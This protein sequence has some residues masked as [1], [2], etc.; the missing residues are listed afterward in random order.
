MISLGGGLPSS[1]Y[2]P[3]ENI[4]VKAP[5]FSSSLEGGMRKTEETLSIGKNDVV[6]GKSAFDLGIA[7]N[8]GQS[9]GA[10]QMVRWVTEHTEVRLR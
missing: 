9:T 5:F 1:E 7:M 4:D 2:F 6:E 3:F 8:Y 10:A